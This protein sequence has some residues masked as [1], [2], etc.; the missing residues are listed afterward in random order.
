MKRIAVV[1]MLSFVIFGCDDGDLSV[2]TF[3][4]TSQ[5][6]SKC[7]NN[8]F[9]YNVNQNEVLILDIPNANF[10]NS[11]T[12]NEA[13]NIV[14]RVYT[15]SSSDK[16]IYR[17]YNGS[18]NNTLLCSDFPASE[19]SVSEEWKALAGA[20]IEITTT[21]NIDSENGGILQI[22]GYTHHIVLKD[23]IFQ[24][25][26]EKMIYQQYVF[27]NYIT[28]NP[29]KFNFSEIIQTCTT[30]DL[31]YK[32]NLQ[33]ALVMN[34]NNQNL[35]IN[36]ETF[37]NPRKAVINST[38]NPIIYK[39]F[40]ANI[41]GAYFC[42]PIPLP[43]PNVVEEWYPENGVEDESGI[44]EVETEKITDDVTGNLI[45]YSHKI[46][47]RKVTFRNNNN[48]FYFSEYYVGTYSVEL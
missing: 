27:G 4:F 47:L 10:R 11:Q 34:L 2:T 30:N 19:P 14:P 28:P 6:I 41:T 9:L 33:E 46:T 29:I 12:V 15:L 24:K 31:L 5:N 22:S 3:N 16:L 42:S 48:G 17:L 26:D 40:D 32:I 37:G 38:T 44:I 20:K 43:T 39:I 18:V 36:Q 45:G 1:F 7:T 23:I 25:G 35:F 13:G 8:T 21:E